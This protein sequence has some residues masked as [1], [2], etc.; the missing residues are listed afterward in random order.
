VILT[1]LIV[2]KECTFGKPQVVLF[3]VQ[4][5]W[6]RVVGSWARR[7][8]EESEACVVTFE[9]W[10]EARRATAMHVLRCIL[11]ASV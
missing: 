2:H 3:E 8:G 11:S 4:L 5:L 1:L 6:Y 9:T 7:S 10:V